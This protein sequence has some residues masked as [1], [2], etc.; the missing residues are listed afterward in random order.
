MK[1]WKFLPWDQEQEYS[2]SLL[3]VNTALEVST[4]ATAQQKEMK[5]VQLRKKDMKETLYT[6]DM[7]LYTE[8]SKDY[9]K[10][11]LLKLILLVTGYKQTY[12]NQLRFY[13]LTVNY[14]KE[15]WRNSIY[16]STKNNKKKI[17]RNKFN[18]GRERVVC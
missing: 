16:N 4:R 10:K 3:L 8:N 12:K 14:L 15:K 1:S 17:H 6:D 9:T 7:P 11:K 13:P 18:K 2:V 5:G